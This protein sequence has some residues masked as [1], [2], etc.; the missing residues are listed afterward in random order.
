MKINTFSLGNSLKSRN[1]IRYVDR[2]GT[3]LNKSFQT[4]TET[5]PLGLK[6]SY[7]L[8]DV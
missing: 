3:L 1:L 2:V 5:G 4:N 6:S 8:L 7:K